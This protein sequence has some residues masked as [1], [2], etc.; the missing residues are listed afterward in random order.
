MPPRKSLRYDEDIIDRLESVENTLKKY[1]KEVEKIKEFFEQKIEENEKNHK[2]EID[3]IKKHAEE[4]E[5]QIL[6]NKNQNMIPIRHIAEENQRSLSIEISKP[7]FFGNN[8]DQHPIDFLQNLEEYFKIKQFSKEEKLIIIRDCLKSAAGNWFATIRFQVREYSE[9]RDAF[10]NEF[11]SREIQIQT[12]SNCLNTSHVSD[13]VT[14]R[15]HFAQWSAKLRHL[16][17]PQI[18][19][20]EIVT[21]IASH[22]R[23]TSEPY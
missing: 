10:I 13:N 21:N 16:Q 14:Y 22:Y 3:I 20:E 5:S 1:K 7:I 6:T 23:D 4:L 17:V 12:W 2:K 8:K 9:F 19:E 11:W 15:E 18:S